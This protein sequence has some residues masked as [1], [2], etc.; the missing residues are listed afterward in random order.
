MRDSLEVSNDSLDESG[1]KMAREDRR[2][3]LGDCE[4][5]EIWVG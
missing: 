2:L 4:R 3:E 5:S 1:K